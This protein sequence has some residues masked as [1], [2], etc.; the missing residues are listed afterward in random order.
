[1]IADEKKLVKVSRVVAAIAI[2]LVGPF[3]MFY[4]AD[5]ISYKQKYISI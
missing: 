2:E 1:M 4:F 3:W 5:V